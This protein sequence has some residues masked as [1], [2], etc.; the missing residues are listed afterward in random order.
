MKWLLLAAAFMSFSTA[1]THAQIDGIRTATGQPF[2]MDARTV[3]G[4][5][6]I[7]GAQPVKKLPNTYVVLFDRRMQMT[8]TTL[9][10]EGCFY[11]RDIPAD[12]GPVI[13][14]INGTEVA[15]Q[16]V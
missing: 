1:V 16:T 8:R 12:G 13:V 2:S 15:R 11:F 14:E 9:D 4:K 6:A 7:D 5:I 3:Y 10:Q